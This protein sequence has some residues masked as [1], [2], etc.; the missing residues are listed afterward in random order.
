MA[1]KARA[2]IRAS[3]IQGLKYFDKLM[4]LLARLHEEGCQRDKAGNRQLH[5]DQYC[6]LMLLAMF[7]P[8]VGSLRA[9]QQ[10]SGLPKVQQRLGVSR[11]S[12]GSLSEAVQV[13][14]PERL[15]EIVEEVGAQL[16]PL[17][18][19]PRLHELKQA[20]T[21]VDGTILTALPQ[22]A[23]AFGG[24]QPTGQRG[25]AW[26]LHTHFEVLRGVPTKL[27]LTAP[28]SSGV[29]SERAVLTSTYSRHRFVKGKAIA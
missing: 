23:A 16:P 2:E 18:A 26:R 22:I 11:A 5:Y 7:S 8:L 3:D 19:D 12:L 14:D 25:F 17:S 10:A 29:S 4:P 20:A 6:V 13:F 9:L 15:R 24:G 1:G 21:L 28:R 27:T